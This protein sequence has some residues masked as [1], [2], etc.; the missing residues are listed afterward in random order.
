[1]LIAVTSF[2]ASATASADSPRSVLALDDDW[3]FHL[4]DAPEA[5]FASFDDSMWRQFDVPHDYVVEGSSS[6]K[7]QTHARV[8]R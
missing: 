6:K 7:I 3:R 1:L 5:C 2:L 8:R 4:G